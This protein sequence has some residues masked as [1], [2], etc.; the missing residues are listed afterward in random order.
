[1]RAFP[2]QLTTHGG[3]GVAAI[4]WTLQPFYLRVRFVIKILRFKIFQVTDA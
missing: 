1:M 3:H 4:V 2:G